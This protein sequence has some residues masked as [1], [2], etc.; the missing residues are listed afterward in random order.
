[1]ATL[2][3]NAKVRHIL[4]AWFGEDD[5]N[6]A[7]E[8]KEADKLSVTKCTMK[9]IVVTASKEMLCS[10]FLS[11]FQLATTFSV[12]QGEQLKFDEILLLTMTWKVR[13]VITMSRMDGQ[14]MK[15]CLEWFTQ[16][17]LCIH[18]SI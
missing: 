2:T 1:L 11:H 18:E 12:S 7:D 3:Q 4:D 14:L 6:E 15:T 16:H 13:A 17:T 8:S 5:E 10:F 9:Q